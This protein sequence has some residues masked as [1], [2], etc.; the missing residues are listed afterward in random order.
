[1]EGEEW[2]LHCESDKEPQEQPPCSAGE[3][4]N[5]PSNC[6]FLQRHK[7]ERPGF[8][9]KPENRRQHEHRSDHGVQEK[10]DCRID[11]PSMPI[12]SDQKGHRN[13]RGFPEKIKKEE[14]ERDK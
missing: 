11:S 7:V 4:G 2:N 6:R 3:I 10:F 1:M 13:Q 5:L 12:H 8:G 9:I 14:I